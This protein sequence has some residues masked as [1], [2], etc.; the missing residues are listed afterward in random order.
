MTAPQALISLLA[1][2]ERERNGAMS[3]AT[4]LEFEHRAAQRQAE[5]LLAYRAEYEQRWSRGFG[6]DGGIAIVHCYRGFM[7][8]LDAALQAQQRV[9]ALAAQRL[10]DAHAQWQRHEIRVASIRK[11]L[12][13]R[14]SEACRAEQ[15]REQKQQD[16][17]AMRSAWLRS[18][19]AALAPL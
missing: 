13:R 9:V 8:R 5:Q 6:G 16:E 2:A 17:H 19:G 1:H 3:D 4:R 18:A 7:D 11:L 15:R 10:A 12:E 14:G